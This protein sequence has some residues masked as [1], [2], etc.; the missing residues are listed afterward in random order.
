VRRLCYVEEAPTP[1]AS[2]RS[3]RLVV[4]NRRSIAVASRCRTPAVTSGRW[5]AFGERRMSKTLPSAPPFGSGA[6]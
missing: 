4:K 6:A 5:L 2:V 3:T 1:S